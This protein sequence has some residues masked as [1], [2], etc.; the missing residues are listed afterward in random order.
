MSTKA[1]RAGRAV[2]Y[3]RYSGRPCEVCGLPYGERRVDRHHID[4]DRLNNKPSNI[5]F[6]CKR[7]HKAAHRQSDGRVG[8]GLREGAG[9]ASR[10]AAKS[11]AVQAAELRHAGMKIVEVAEVLGVHPVSVMRWWRKYPETRS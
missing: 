1:D 9:E 3:R 11:R 10:R 8:G 4:S 7:H 6:L 5:A 2:A